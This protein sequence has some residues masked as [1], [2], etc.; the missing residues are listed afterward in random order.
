MSSNTHEL[1]I[2]PQWFADVST[3][4]KNFE[5]RRNDRDFK[6]GDYLLLKEWDKGRYTGREITKRIQYIYEGD[7]TYGLSDE[8]CILGLEDRPTG[9]WI[10]KPKESSQSAIL[11]CNKCNHFIPITIDKNYCPNC[12]SKMKQEAENE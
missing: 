5:I 9:E 8:F 4:K 7:G 10:I 2:L 3:G 11:I 12:G 1:K 6:V